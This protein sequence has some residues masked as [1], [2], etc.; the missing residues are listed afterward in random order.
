ML[1]TSVNESG[2]MPLNDYETIVAQYQDVVDKIY[3]P[4]KNS[5]N[6]SST[7]IDLTTGEMKL[8]R[9]GTLAFEQIKII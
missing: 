9:E 6:I 3:P 1:T 2:E 8:L 7:V 4:Q 5:S